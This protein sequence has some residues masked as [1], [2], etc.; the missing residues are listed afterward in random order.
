MEL[1]H[2]GNENVILGIPFI[3][4]YIVPADCYSV[5]NPPHTESFFFSGPKANNWRVSALERMPSVSWHESISTFESVKGVVTRRSSGNGI[6]NRTAAE[7]QRV[8]DGNA[9]AWHVSYLLPGAGLQKVRVFCDIPL[10]LL[11][12]KQFAKKV[13]TWNPS[14]KEPCFRPTQ[15]WVNSISRYFFW[16][17][18]CAVA[19][20]PC[21]FRTCNY[22][23]FLP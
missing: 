7:W 17:V 23:V 18:A 15:C 22:N 20:K 12:N 16:P 8:F 5:P 3:V 19:H 10:F 11:N 9:M 6:L 1:A 14:F 21:R 2:D 13:G 4:L